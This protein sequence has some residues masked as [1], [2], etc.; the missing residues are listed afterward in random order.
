MPFDPTAIRAYIVSNEDWRR[1]VYVDNLGIPTIGVGFNLQRPDAQ[2]RLIAFGLDYQK[3][4]NGTQLLSDSQV[5]LLFSQ[6][7]DQAV[8]AV[9]RLV[10]N[11]DNLTPGRQAVLVD[12]GFNLGAVGLGQFTRMLAAVNAGRWDDARNEM[13]DSAW[14]SQVGTRATRNAIAIQSGNNPIPGGG[15]PKPL[16]AKPG[17]DAKEGGDKGK[18]GQKDA[19]DKGADKPG[20][21]G[22]DGQKDALDKG[23]DKGKDASEKAGDKGKDTAE[24]GSDK[25]KDDVEKGADKGK[26][27]KEGK[28]GEKDTS[29]KGKEAKDGKDGEKDTSDKGKEGKDG[30]KDTSDKGKEAKDGKDGEKDTSDKGKEGKDRKDDKDGKEELDLL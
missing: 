17:K 15:R 2:A 27:T 18:D 3:V 1:T 13:E 7:L 30:E 4:L 11:F 10:P 22:K 9:R 19:S 8:S 28:D 29:D 25:G 24:K 16:D 6:D 21:K 26:D 5:D 20:D 14:F 12:M 23:S